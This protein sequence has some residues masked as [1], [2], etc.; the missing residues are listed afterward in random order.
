VRKTREKAASRTKPDPDRLDFSAIERQVEEDLCKKACGDVMEATARTVSLA[1][2]PD[3][4]VAICGSVAK[5]MFEVAMEAQ[6]TNIEENVWGKK[7][8]ERKK[9]SL[10]LMQ[11]LMLVCPKDIALRIYDLLQ[12]EGDR[13][14]METEKLEKTR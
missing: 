14:E 5:T 6:I 7:M 2:T 11:A 8:S 1:P 12:K 13:L 4:A 3:I 10:R 9:G